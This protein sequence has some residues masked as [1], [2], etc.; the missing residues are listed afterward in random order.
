MPR[1]ESSPHVMVCRILAEVDDL[2][3]QKLPAKK[4][5]TAL[6]QCHRS[7]PFL[8]HQP[9]ARD[10]RFSIESDR[11]THD[12]SSN[13]RK[14]LIRRM[15]PSVAVR[16]FQSPSVT[17]RHFQ[18]PSVTVRRGEPHNQFVTDHHH[19]GTL[20]HLLPQSITIT[21]PSEFVFVV[22]SISVSYWESHCNRT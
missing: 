5:I 20:H 4:I 22:P 9:L 2:L 21:V 14:M 7:T 11:V 3:P 19:Q 18:S 6:I 10:R 16:R 15:T 12:E 17:V 8:G 13:M 1:T